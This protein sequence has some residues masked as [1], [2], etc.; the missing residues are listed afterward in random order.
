MTDTFR[1]SDG[2]TLYSVGDAWRDSRDEDYDLTF[3]AD[4]DG[5]PIHPFGERLKGEFM[6]ADPAVQAANRLSHDQ[7]VRIAQETV[8]NES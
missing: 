2:Y 1:T 4:A 5:H 8:D 3:S 7:L 6:E